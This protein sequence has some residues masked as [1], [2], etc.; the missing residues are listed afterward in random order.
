M[1]SSYDNKSCRVKTFRKFLLEYV[2]SGC[3]RAWFKTGYKPSSGVKLIQQAQQQAQ[4]RQGQLPPDAQ[5][6][7]DTSMA[8]TQRKTQADQAK[9]QHD[10]AKLQA[11]QQ[12]AAMDNQ[13]KIAIENAKL[14]HEAITNMVQPA[15]PAAPAAQP[16][17]QAAPQPQGAENG[18]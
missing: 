16:A 14:T 15:P 1:D 17:A 9:Q 13:T 3:V 2:P 7:K 5:V 18:Q 11:D 12:K 10:Q 4:A 6:V 8:E